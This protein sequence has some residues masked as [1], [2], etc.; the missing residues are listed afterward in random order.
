MVT[1]GSQVQRQKEGVP[2]DGDG[3]EVPEPPAGGMG[4]LKTDANKLSQEK[5]RRKMNN[6][7]LL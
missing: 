1:G 2:A 5:C 7:H 3:V 4:R 6:V